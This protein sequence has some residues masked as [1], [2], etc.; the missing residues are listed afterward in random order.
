MNTSEIEIANYLIK[1]YVILLP[2]EQMEALKHHKH[3]LK[4]NEMPDN[5]ARRQLYEKANWLTSDPEVLKLLDKDISTSY[6]PVPTRYQE[7]IR[8]RFISIIAQN[9]EG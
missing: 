3:A 1:Y 4:L 2:V 5:E 6:Y 9:A 8:M 7:S